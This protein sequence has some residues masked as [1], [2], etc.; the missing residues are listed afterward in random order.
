MAAIERIIISR[1]M[2]GA[3]PRFRFSVS[4][5][6]ALK[7]VVLNKHPEADRSTMYTHLLTQMCAFAGK[8]LPQNWRDIFLSGETFTWEFV[9]NTGT[10]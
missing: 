8:N 10:D 7:Q 1:E 2:F 9:P 3:E 6:Q 5:R 4:D